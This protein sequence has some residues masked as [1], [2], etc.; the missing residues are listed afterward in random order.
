[1]RPTI[2]LETILPELSWEE[3]F[4][5]V[6]D[7]GFDTVELWAVGEEEAPALRQM[8]DR[9][10]VSLIGLSGDMTP[11]GNDPPM[12]DYRRQDE[13][14]ALVEKTM[15]IAK[16]LGATYLH[17]HSGRIQNA[18]GLTSEEMFASMVTA[19]KRLAPVAEREGLVLLV[20]NCET[21]W[22]S[23]GYYLDRAEKVAR[24][25]RMVDS[26]NIRFIYDLYHEQVM[27]GDLL[28]T[29]H[30][31]MDIIPYIHISNVP[32]KC[33]LEEGEIRYGRIAEELSAV[34]FDGPLGF[35]VISHG[36]WKQTFEQIHRFLSKL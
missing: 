17:C 34:A 11:E 9:F 15:R 35:E 24:L 21:K 16:V 20:E 25:I 5:T 27:A 36:N 4:Q 6:R 33:D 26:P 18:S 14:C 8:A 30:E 28:R 23:P 19:L 32:Q 22:D 29:L 2:I 10:G 13:Y 1:M 7:N 12:L 31:N 3:R